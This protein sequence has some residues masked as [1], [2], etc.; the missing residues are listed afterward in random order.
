MIKG[1]DFLAKRSLYTI[2]AHATILR[3]ILRKSANTHIPRTAI[4]IKIENLY[5][6]SKIIAMRIYRDRFK[7]TL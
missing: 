6:P 5:Q 1:E 4:L 7:K 3:T 2:S